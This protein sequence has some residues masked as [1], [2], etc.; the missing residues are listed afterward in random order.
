MLKQI[1]SKVDQLIVA[2]IVSSP[3]KPG[4]INAASDNEILQVSSLHLLQG[5]EVKSH[6]HLPTSR[7][8][9]GTQE[10]WV[11]ISGSIQTTVFDVDAQP[12]ETLTLSAGQVMVLYRGGHNLVVTSPDAVIFEIKNGPYFG[13]HMDAVPI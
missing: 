12:I 1:Y 8:T 9:I 7:S 4:R 2:A 11:V 13:S 10:A 5:K 6:Q 3:E